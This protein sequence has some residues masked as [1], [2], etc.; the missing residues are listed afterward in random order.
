[1][2][3]GRTLRTQEAQGVGNDT[4]AET[5]EMHICVRSHILLL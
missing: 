3:R 4:F 5:C 1:M 2:G